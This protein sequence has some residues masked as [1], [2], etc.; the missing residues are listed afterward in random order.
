MGMTQ[1]RALYVFSVGNCNS[2]A[3]HSARCSAPSLRLMFVPICIPIDAMHS[4]Q[5]RRDRRSTH[6]DVLGA[7]AVDGTSLLLRQPLRIGNPISHSRTHVCTSG[8][9]NLLVSRFTARVQEYLSSWQRQVLRCMA[10]HLVYSDVTV[11]Q[12]STTSS[13]KLLAA[14]KLALLGR[15][16]RHLNRTNWIKLLLGQAALRF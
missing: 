4:L 6:I 5:E 11:S 10:E 14:K 3:H 7:S 15:H 2:D 13:M 8:G 1:S 9:T 16:A 12:A